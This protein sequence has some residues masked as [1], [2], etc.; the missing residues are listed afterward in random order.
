[1]GG[2]VGYN[3]VSFTGQGAKAGRWDPVLQS[4]EREMRRCEMERM[5]YISLGKINKGGRRIVL[6]ASMY[7]HDG[8]ERLLY[9]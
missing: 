8:Q 4:V 9:T 3:I 7:G 1:L 2:I 6:S 5:R